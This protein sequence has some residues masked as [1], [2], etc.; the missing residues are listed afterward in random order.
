[1]R[2]CAEVDWE[3]EHRGD[4]G[5][6]RARACDVNQRI[7]A[8]DEALP[9]FAQVSRNIATMMA[10]LY[11]LLEA[12]TPKDR[13]AHHEIRMLLERAAAQQA[14]SSLSRRH[15]LNASQRTT[16]ACPARDT[17]VH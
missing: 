17:S 9:R 7:I 5:R 15:E 1:M 3:I 2:E 6:A 8:D 10:L 12:T 14:E 13:Q 16:S 4:G 11:G